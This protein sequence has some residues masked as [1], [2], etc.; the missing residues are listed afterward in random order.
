MQNF[1][2]AFS[3]SKSFQFV[4]EQLSREGGSPRR[5]DC[6]GPPQLC[7]VGF[8]EDV[9]RRRRLPWVVRSDLSANDTGEGWGSRTEHF[10]LEVLRG[11]GRIDSCAT[12][13]CRELKL[14][15]GYREISASPAARS[16]TLFNPRSIIRVSEVLPMR[17]LLAAT[18]VC[19]LLSAQPLALRARDVTEKPHFQPAEAV[20]V[21]EVTKP[22]LSIASGTVVLDVMISEEGEV[23]NVQVRRDI[24]SLT[25]EAVRFVRTWT[26][27]PAKF[28]GKAVTSRMTVAV[29]FNPASV[30]AA[31]VPL[32]P[33][34]HQDDEARIQSSFQ[35]P[36]VT[37][38]TFPTYPFDAIW[39]GT[40][41]IEATINKAGKVQSTKVLRD[42]P[43]FTTKAIQAVEH[44]RF[45]PAT[46]NARPLRA[47]AILAFVFPPLPSSP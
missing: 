18:A 9:T 7:Q 16:R 42:V 25:E 44:W 47:K 28:D 23:I 8:R 5:H 35:P 31:N 26:F 27:E 38:A 39:P 13:V 6:H 14:C 4:N 43:P 17:R 11:S 45:T 30:L 20:S 3:R 33:L 37:C 46:L 29:T 24:V 22:F 32:P 34:I 1:I 40:V 10:C 15:H 19:V 21:N 12:K 36:E 41:V 2:S